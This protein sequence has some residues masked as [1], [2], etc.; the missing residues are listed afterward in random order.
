MNGRVYKVTDAKGTDITEQINLGLPYMVT[1]KRSA[2]HKVLSD[3][4]ARKG[5]ADDLR[6]VLQNLHTLEQEA[7]DYIGLQDGCVL[8]LQKDGVQESYTLETPHVFVTVIDNAV[9]SSL[10]DVAE[11]TRAVADVIRETMLS[12]ASQGIWANFP[13]EHGSELTASFHAVSYIETARLWN[14]RINEYV[15]RQARIA[16]EMEKVRSAKDH[17]DPMVAEFLGAMAGILAERSFN[18]SQV[19]DITKLVREAIEAKRCNRLQKGE[20]HA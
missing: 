5:N 20:D 10:E 1:A 19:A 7:K 18:P 6:K 15:E 2:L 17:N 16:A 11:H 12:D 13:D 8:H 9:D 4:Y 14:Y 3:V